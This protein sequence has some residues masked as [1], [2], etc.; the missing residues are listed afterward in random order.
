[1]NAAWPEKVVV[2]LFGIEAIV[3]MFFGMTAPNAGSDS[4][5]VAFF[6]TFWRIPL[7]TLLPVWGFLRLL[8]WVSGGFARRSGTFILPPPR[9]P[10]E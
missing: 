10:G 4:W 6:A 7:F 3:L 9:W 2:A 1:M 8:D 5:I